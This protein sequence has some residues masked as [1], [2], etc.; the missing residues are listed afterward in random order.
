MF[1][2]VVAAIDWSEPSGRAVEVAKELAT[3]S[4]GEVRLLHVHEVERLPPHGGGPLAKTVGA[5]ATKGEEEAVQHVA[6][7]ASKMT[8]AGVTATCEVRV[9]LPG[10]VAAEIVEESTA[11]KADAIVMGSRGLTDLAGILLGS[12]THKVL[13]LTS[14]PVVVVR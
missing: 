3:L 9:S 13:H 12:T 4:G 1:Q 8:D 10:R 14:I 11:W 7:A 6:A 2:R 5:V